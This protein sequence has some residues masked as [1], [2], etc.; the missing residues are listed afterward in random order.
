MLL[1]VNNRKY[2]RPPA[3]NSVSCRD[4]VLWAPSRPRVSDPDVSSL[5]GKGP[6]VPPPT[7]DPDPVSNLVNRPYGCVPGRCTRPEG[8]LPH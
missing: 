2:E 5:Q 1:L 3:V 8:V 7:T 4:E 6:S